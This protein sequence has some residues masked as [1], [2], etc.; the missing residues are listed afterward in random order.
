[1]LAMAAL[2]KGDG[3]P[4]L[5]IYLQT[6]GKIQPTCPGNSTRSASMA[7]QEAGTA[8][9]CGEGLKATRTLEAFMN[10]T[11]EL[12]ELSAFNDIWAQTT[13]LQCLGWDIV[14]KEIFTGPFTG[15]TSFPLLVI[16]NTM[17]P[18]TPL[19]AAKKASEGFA[20]SV[21][22]TVNTPGHCSPAGTSLA[23]SKHIRNY[24]RDGILP[25]KDTVCEIEDKFFE[26]GDR[27]GQAEDK[28]SA[29]SVEDREL[30][31]VTKSLS[32]NFPMVGLGML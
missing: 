11:E 12:E 8:V 14:A 16:G 23:V 20:N 1:M 2:E 13:R 24:F 25:P 10:Y 7:I 4:M 29:L 18:V 3:R 19:M 17:D 21:L 22:L 9:M 6:R 32:R 31:E 5:D 15:N 28:T 26:V 27:D 30:L